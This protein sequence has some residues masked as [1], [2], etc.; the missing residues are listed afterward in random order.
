MTDDEDDV[1]G[2]VGTGIRLVEFDSV[3]AVEIMGQDVVVVVRV[4]SANVLVTLL[5]GQLWEN[6]FGIALHIHRIDN[7]NCRQMSL[8]FNHAADRHQIRI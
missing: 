4:T 8:T 6:L 2:V 5:H 7:F 3:G 1:G